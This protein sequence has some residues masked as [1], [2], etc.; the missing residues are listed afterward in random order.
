MFKHLYFSIYLTKIS[1]GTVTESTSVSTK[2]SGIES[3][4]VSTT[5]T[6]EPESTSMP[7]TTT[8]VVTGQ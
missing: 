4:A 8:S 2:I 3:T 6:S 7:T 1:I 5:T